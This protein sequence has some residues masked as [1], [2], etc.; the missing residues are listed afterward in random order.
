VALN[1]LEDLQSKVDELSFFVS[2]KTKDAE[3][4]DLVPLRFGVEVS[5]KEQTGVPDVKVEAGGT[6]VS[7]GSVYSQEV[8]FKSLKP[9]IVGTGLQA[10]KFGWSP[11]A[12]AV[13]GLVS[14]VAPDVAGEIHGR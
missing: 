13:Q 2:L 11:Q 9:T 14:D 8:T 7:I 1:P 5:K 10:A 4:L 6:G 3:A 12:D